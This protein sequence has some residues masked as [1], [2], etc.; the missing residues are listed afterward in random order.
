[1]K[2]LVSFVLALACFGLPGTHGSNNV[3]NKCLPNT[4]LVEGDSFG[5]L[6]LSPREC[7]SKCQQDPNC[8]FFIFFAKSS[9]G[10][11]KL[12]KGTCGLRNFHPN[13]R[14]FSSGNL[15][16]LKNENYRRWTRK[17]NSVWVGKKIMHVETCDDCFKRC[18]ED[19]RCKSVIHSKSIQ[20]CTFNYGTE[21][22]IAL[23]L[24]PQAQISSAQKYSRLDSCVAKCDK[25]TCPDNNLVKGC[26]MQYSCAHACKIRDLG[27]SKWSCER[28]CN[29]S[30]PAPGCNPVVKGHKFELC[31]TGTNEA[32]SQDGCPIRP[33][34]P[35]ARNA[36]CAHVWLEN[37]K[38]IAE[39]VAGCNNY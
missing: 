37:D 14:A 26:N 2:L 35:T 6:L 13:E 20:Q 21:P 33:P 9:G 4:L 1:M 28:M 29:R 10:L 27:V 16:G 38:R 18:K 19:H 17:T 24:P 23:A 25:M 7:Q 22:L 11:R 36:L 3:F 32:G 15:S 31:R 39:C 5:G 30:Y 34:R 8:D 12:A